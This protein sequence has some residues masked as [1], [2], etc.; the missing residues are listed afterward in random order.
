[1]PGVQAQDDGAHARQEGGGVNK[2]QAQ[3]VHALRRA[4]QR[5][6]V[7][8]SEEDLRHIAHLVTRNESRLVRRESNRISIREVEY[9]GLRFCIAWDHSRRQVATVLPVREET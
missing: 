8:W 6:G 7:R 3:R 5:L 2:R 9:A 1:M 4:R